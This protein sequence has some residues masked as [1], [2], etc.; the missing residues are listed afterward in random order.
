MATGV[1]QE[2]SWHAQLER[3]LNEAYPGR[4]FEFINFGVEYYGLREVVAT[5]R[6]RVPKW[7][8]D[9]I[10][11]DLTSFTAY[12]LWESPPANLPLPDKTSPFLQSFALRALDANLEAGFFSQRLPQRPTVGLDMNLAHAQVVR[13]IREVHALAASQQIPVI[14]SWLSFGRPGAALLQELEQVSAELGLIFIPAYKSIQQRGLRKGA[15]ITA[16]HPD[17]ET[18]AVIANLVRKAMAANNLLPLEQ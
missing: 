7:D 18:H 5:V 15:K 17:S 1:A 9:V 16:K 4:H 6:H 12:L 3:D 11:I 2:S 14:V 13:A 8:P 10:H